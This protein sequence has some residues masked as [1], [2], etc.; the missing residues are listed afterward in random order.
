MADQRSPLQSPAAPQS[1]PGYPQNF[2]PIIFDGFE[3]LN[4]KPTRPAIEDQQC[5]WLDNFMP[6]GKSNLRTLYDIGTPIFLAPITATT[7][8]PNDQTG[9][10]LSGGN[11][12]ANASTNA[13]GGV[14]AIAGKTMGKF[15]FEAIHQVATSSGSSVGVADALASRT[16]ALGADPHGYGI[17][18]SGAVYH[19]GVQVGVVSAFVLG[20]V[21]GIAVDVSAKRMWVRVNGGVWN[22]SGAADPVTGASGINVSG[23]STIYPMAIVQAA[24]P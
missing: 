6:L 21:V 23:I 20:D 12:I 8:N 15:Y 16:S 2:Q 1:T 24:G 22:G 17:R 10:T 4:T 5:F 14:R 9:I 13:P 11:L 19:S 3:G 7:W 18:P